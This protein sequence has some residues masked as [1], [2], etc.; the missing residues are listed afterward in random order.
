MSGG[1]ADQRA[2]PEPTRR[3]D[4]AHGR[5]AGAATGAWARGE[6]YAERAKAWTERQERTTRLGVGIGS[7]E[8]Y[9]EADGQLYALLL[10]AYV[11]VTLLPA[12]L[13]VA[14]YTADDPEAV[15]DRL[16]ARLDLHGATATLTRQVLAGAGGHQFT[17]TL[18]AVV[19]VITFGAG[20]ARS[21]QLLYARAWRMPAKGL[22]ITDQLRYYT[23]LLAFMVALLAYVVATALLTKAPA[24]I[25]TALMPVWAAAGVAFLAWTPAFLLHRRVTVRDALPG[26]LLAAIGLVG[27]RLLSGLEL[28]NWLNWYSKYYGALGIVI[29]IFFWLLLGATVLVATAAMS[30]AYAERRRARVALKEALNAPETSP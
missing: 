16:I 12:S 15:A 29:A 14:S 18:I 2:G 27:L 28:T 1:P 22:S 10:S 11:F 23:W 5:V 26:A 6:R 17:A 30:P 20:M 25:D 7:F 9:R 21:L 3:R 24:W 8:R 19:S 4:K 13:A